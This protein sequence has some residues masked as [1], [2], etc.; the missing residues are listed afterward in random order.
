MSIRAIVVAAVA[1]AAA[2]GI[3]QE[4][5]PESTLESEGYRC[6]TITAEQG[7]VRSCEN[8]AWIVW[9]L[10]DGSFEYAWNFE[11]GEFEYTESNVPPGW[12]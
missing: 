6:Q 12:Q 9:V 5:V 1:G 3:G 4:V 7:P 11:S 8:D 10:P 2:M